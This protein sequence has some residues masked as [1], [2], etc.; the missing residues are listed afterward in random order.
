MLDY[1]CI[2]N[3]YAVYISIALHSFVICISI[4]TQ[5][6]LYHNLTIFDNKHVGN[7]QDTYKIKLWTSTLN[8]NATYQSALSHFPA[9]PNTPFRMC[10]LA[11]FLLEIRLESE[12]AFFA[13]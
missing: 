1:I 3:C 10:S 13:S 2:I 4:Y 5:Y 7:I 8:E 12:H 6:L 9:Y 11:P